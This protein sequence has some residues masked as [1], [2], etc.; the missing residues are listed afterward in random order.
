M[1]QLQQP[2]QV[3][4][5]FN[6]WKL[7]QGLDIQLL[8]KAIQDIIKT[9]PDLNVRYTFSD[10]GD[11]YKYPFDDHSACLELKKS[12][13]E[14]VFEQVATLKA[15]AWNAEFHPPFF[16]S[17]VE[18]EQDYFLIL[19]LHPILDESYQK[20]D[21][22]QAIQNRYQQYSPNN[23]PLVLTEIDISNH[24]AANSTKAPEQANQNYVSEIIL[25]EFRNT[26]AEPEM[27]Q[28]DD[29]FDFGGHS[30][31]ATRIIGNLLNKHGIEIQF[32]DFFK[33]PSAADL[34]QYAFVKTAKTEKTTLQSVDQAPLTLA[35]DFL[36]QAYSA[37]D[38]SPIYNLPFAVEFLEEINEDVFLQAFTDI[39]ERHAGLRT[40]FNSANGQTYQQV[41]PTSELKKFKWFW[42]SAESKDATLA[43]EASYKFDLTRELPLRIRLIRNAKGRQTLS[44]LVHH[45]VIDEWSL[46]TIMADLAHAYLAR[47]NAQAPSWKAPAQSILDFSLLQQ[48]QGINQ[49][50][51]NYWTNLLTGATKGLSLPVS[52]HEL[53]AEKEKPPVQWLELKFAPEM[54][55]KLLAF[56]RQ[57]SSSIFTVLYTAIANALQQQGNLKD[58]VIGTSASGRTD[59]EFFDTVGYFTTM[60]AHRTQFSPSDSFQS[61]LHNIS[62]MINTSMAYADIPINH[63]QN[64]LGM[65]ADEGLLFDVFI[66]IHSNNALNGALK[67]P[68]GQDLP[69]RQILP[70]RDESMF[71]LH[72]EIMEN[73]ID[74]Q[75]QLSM[76]ITYQAHRFPTATVQSIC[77]KIK[78]TLAQI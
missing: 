66:H 23:V 57:H 40:I 48:K 12:N 11:L 45:M 43:S 2:E 28:H 13:T 54:H 33:S 63:I 16:T 32:N 64:A 74:G 42:N 35:Q 17:L 72:F 47:S 34:A 55:E 76:I 73:V 67:T 15:Q 30:L 46:N 38:F 31:L 70:E 1:L 9:T 14:Q 78:A 7:N 69:Y 53:N 8:I 37:F 61:L 49:D 44:F 41:I 24:L 75:H 29:F 4:R 10:E 19:A 6:L 77:E 3:N 52:E 58:I 27:S 65:S 5:R 68:Q 22:I 60:V 71:G 39:V 62:T 51:L 59:P 50:H 18:T 21:F 26:L 56:S 36:W 25:E 20:S